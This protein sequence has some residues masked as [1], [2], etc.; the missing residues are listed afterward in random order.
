MGRLA[1]N[2]RIGTAPVAAPRGPV[3]GVR[4]RVLQQI[5]ASASSSMTSAR[6]M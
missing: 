2:E 4:E 5:R 6:A 3:S 1:I